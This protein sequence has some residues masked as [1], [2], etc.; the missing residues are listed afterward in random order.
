MKSLVIDIG[1]TRMKTGVFFENK[2]LQYDEIPQEQEDRIVDIITEFG[3]TK[4]LVS[5]VS[6][7]SSIVLNQL[8]TEIQILF[9]D[10]DTRL[11]FI[12][13][14]KSKDTLGS[15]RKAL[16]A[17]A[18]HFYEA[19]NCL[20]IDAGTC[21]TYDIL[22]EKGAYQGGN[23]T[24]G[25][26]MRLQAMNHFTGKLPLPD[27]KLPEELIGSNTDDCLLSGAF[28]GLLG[29]IQYFINHYEKEYKNLKVL[30]TGGDASILAKPIKNSIFVHEHL[31]LYGL[32]KILIENVK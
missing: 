7:H 10:K 1:N 30:L 23:I 11:P 24:P 16:V 15:D 28:Y 3:I 32:N 19:R 26:Q 2:L 21:V 17:G 12:N 29:E 8:K 20:I 13:N 18:S 14:Y 22:T 27:W 4:I 6:L 25:L 31:L 9:L 5:N